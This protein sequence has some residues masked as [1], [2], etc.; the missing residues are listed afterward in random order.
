M[1]LTSFSE[2]AT[3]CTNL[4]LKIRQAAL[5][6]IR[7]MS[8]LR[9]DQKNARA[10]TGALKDL[11]RQILI[12]CLLCRRTFALDKESQQSMFG[13]VG[14]VTDYIEASVH[15]H[16]H[17]NS[18]SNQTT[19]ELEAKMLSD[20]YLARRVNGLIRVQL[21]RDD[22]AISVG[23]KRF[24]STAALTGRWRFVHECDQ[25]WIENQASSKVV[26]Y[27]LVTGSLLVSGRAISQLPAHYM[28]DPLYRSVF[29]DLELDVFAADVDDMEYVSKDEI[30][31]HRIYFAMRGKALLIRSCSGGQRF[32]AVHRDRFL[33][34]V[35]RAIVESSTP[36]MSLQDTTV[37][38]RS[39]DRP[40][41]PDLADWTLS[42]GF[43][44]GSKSTMST[45]QKK[46]IDVNGQFGASICNI[47][48][49]IESSDN[50]IITV[51][52]ESSVEVELPRYHLHF[53]LD[54]KGRL[55][56]RE[57]SA[58]VDFDQQLGTFHGLQSRLIL[59]AK[60]EVA[61]SRMRTVL[62]PI[63]EV[64]ITSAKPHVRVEVQLDDSDSLSLSQ[65][66]IDERLGQLVGQDLEAHLYKV[67]LHAITTFPELDSLTRR[68]G[69]EESLFALSDPICRTCLPL[70]M[71]A[72]NILGLISRLT[73]VRRFYPVHLKTM[74]TTTFL[75]GLS[76]VA[77]RDIFFGTANE[78]VTHNMKAGCLF[79]AQATPLHYDGQFELLQRS[80]HRTRKL[81][82]SESVASAPHSVADNEYCSRDQ[83]SNE[84]LHAS[85][86][87]ARLVGL[88]PS[89]LDVTPSLKDL[90][91][92]W[93]KIR[94]FHEETNA[95]AFTS[96]LV[97][98]MEDLLPR[99]IALCRSL[100]TSRERLAF[101]LSLI[102]FGGPAG[103]QL[104]AFGGHL[105]AALAFAI[106]PALR[107]LPIPDH[108][109]YDLSRGY[110]IDHREVGTLISLCEKEFVPSEATS[111]SEDEDGD[112]ISAEKI[113]FEQELGEQRRLILKAVKSSWPG[114]EVNFTSVSRKLSHYN[115]VDLKA[116]LD[117]RFAA[118]HKNYVFLIQLEAYDKVLVSIRSS[119]VGPAMV[120]LVQDFGST[121]PQTPPG[122]HFSLLD[123][124][125]R[126]AVTTGDY[127]ES[128][129]TCLDQD[130]S[131]SLSGKQALHLLISNQ[132]SRSL[133]ELENIVTNLM[134]DPTES[135]RC[136]G[137]LIGDS[138]K[139]SRHR[140][141]QELIKM[142]V[143]AETVLAAK[144]VES[145]RHIAYILS[146]TQDLIQP[147]LPSQQGLVTARLWP[148]VSE[149]SLLQLL[150]IDH[151]RLV[152]FTWMP[153]LVQLAKE[154]T[155]AQRIERL[156][157]FLA[158][159]D[160]FALNNE[161]A[162]PAHSAWSPESRLDWLLL[163]CQN[164]MLIRPV[165]LRVADELLKPHNGVVLLGMGEGKTSVIL[166]MVA[167]ALAD[168][169]NLVRVV[170]L[171]P[172]A[173]EM[174]RTL[175]LSLAGLVGR[176]L[177]YLPF[178]RQTTLTSETP[179]LLKSLYDECRQ[180]KGILL[181]LPEYL[182]SF[183][184]VGLDKLGPGT[185][186][187][188][189]P[190]YELVYTNGEA[191][192][193][194][195]APKRWNVA[196][197]ILDVVRKNANDLQR[198]FPTAF[199]V[200]SRGQGCFPHIRVLDDSGATP[201]ARVVTQAI[202]DGHIPTLSLGHCN[203]HVLQAISAFILDIDV[204]D[205][206]FRLLTEHF[207]DA[208]KFDL[209]YV[210]RGLISHGILSHTLGKRWLV[211]YGLD[212][213]RTLS[214]VPYRAKGFS[215][216][217]AE[218][219]Q[220]EA[221]ILLTALSFYY[222]GLLRTDLRRCLLILM[223]LPD[224]ADA[225][226]KWVRQSTLPKK[227][228]RAASINLDDASCVD[229]LYTHLKY[230]SE[231]I[232]FFLRHVVYPSEAKEFRYKLS[233]SAWDL[234]RSGKVVTGG[235]S[236]TCDSRIP[237]IQK[238]LPD[239]RHIPATTLTTLLRWENRQ[240][241][242]AASQSG[243]RLT[244]KDLLQ[245]IIAEGPVDVC[246]DVGAQMLEGN[247]EIAHL[248][249]HLSPKEK[250]AAIYFSESDQKM[251]LNRD[252]STEPLVSSI[253][254]DEL[255]SCLIFLDE[256][257]TRG[258]DFQLPD[259]FT[260]AVLL[261][262]DILKDS[263]AQACMRMRKLA[264]SQSVRF[265]APPEVDQAIRSV[266]K[267]PSEEVTSLHVVLWAIK[268]SCLT[269]K[270]QG[271]LYATRGLLHS[272]RRLAAE[273][274]VSPEGD[275]VNPESYLDTVRERECRPVSELYRVDRRSRAAMPFEPTVEEVQ[276]AV[277]KELVLEFH[278]TSDSDCQDNGITQEQEREILHEVEEERELQ[279]PREVEP[280]TPHHC[281]SLLDHV[282]D[283][284]P[285][286]GTSELRPCFDVLKQT[287]LDY[288]YKP[289]E[290]PMHV[291]VTPDFLQTIIPVGNSPQDDFLRPVQWVLKTWGLAQPVIISSH[292][293]Q[294][295]LPA[296]R[297]SKRTTL[298]MYQARTSRDM[299]PFDGLDICKIPDNNRS[300]E[301]KP[302]AI[303]LL[304]LFA[305]QL[306]FSSFN[307]YKT[308]CTVI[309][310]FDGERPLPHKRNV[311]DDNFVS[312][313]CRLANDWTE[314][315]FKTSPVGWIKSFITM[316]RL[317]IEWSHTH[318][319]RVLNGKILRREDFD[320]GDDVEHG[321]D[322]VEKMAGLTLDEKDG[323]DDSESLNAE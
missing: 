315:T 23:V 248:W 165:Q 271:P 85:S 163:E 96:L 159:G 147:L 257:H 200:E 210:V 101:V 279:R 233:T 261:G 66:R 275:I 293:A 79:D 42:P 184:L 47:F 230:N 188:A 123:R 299:V 25:T 130:L 13:S 240:Y 234:C 103:Q 59:R 321:K 161:L 113:Q 49:P 305:G 98:D 110:S 74:Q 292:E 204:E 95:D 138:I 246:I 286:P 251:V 10:D 137:K 146:K 322:L 151:R 181:T 243:G 86:T 278:V 314:C 209:L 135:V 228:Q 62:V 14:A 89:A 284:T 76:V 83:D 239:L 116:L 317:G 30:H 142:K 182:N 252:G 205:S 36:W 255:G 46:L 237:I 152:P 145:N 9:T 33:G 227:Y 319:G 241:F 34:D 281:R 133:E 238:D 24:W 20:A 183:R 312:P 102:V 39:R 122:T 207:Q 195:G 166:P 118:W 70:S 41:C 245:R 51:T 316:R 117:G 111:S 125:Q 265:Y 16:T 249:L 105:R 219:A 43:N 280:A 197:D 287:R 155:A 69:T 168:G 247:L 309:G 313:T 167:T 218:F 270:K 73:P 141:G 53:D 289:K 177:Y 15:L 258:T 259:N 176:A 308:M 29:G 267:D 320:E 1:S 229:E 323:M 65:F 37:V 75:K 172:L 61:G 22:S 109:D 6:W 222:T 302:L 72:Q 213:S 158:T 154:I 50:I 276:D 173:Q 19:L 77:Q 216:P 114:D 198:R 297:A 263:L 120:N 231:L 115:L 106:S 232:H 60:T 54:C 38:F 164:N 11:S 291:L 35:P 169:M 223:R 94:G 273:R 304:N 143:P 191:N 311:A 290:F 236:G 40:F 170:V 104:L 7:Q 57:L 300:G 196:L 92:G 18:V 8:K 144:L 318:M 55:V 187:L 256:F 121:S 126:T 192:L 58:F 156:Q 269:L 157:K 162:N 220:P 242:S 108:D 81:F 260:A 48:L 32:E 253:F 235:F 202:V 5:A 185:H 99:L 208:G 17:R 64:N 206:Q 71:R 303:A 100:S 217:S 148:Q 298:Y 266:M 153:I 26:H 225:Y 91:L 124:M 201:L 307:H 78:I 28:A 4:N 174:L 93:Q 139:A 282:R 212:R 171:K 178:S 224:P 90:V 203:P 129:P 56:C 112:V 87:M 268:Q 221:A 285:F 128:K 175:S 190:S 44:S 277:M 296:I 127:N 250:L 84:H 199:E 244:T 306:Y 107:A 131:Q 274:H 262:P 294:L 52:R 254:K 180:M 189:R 288:F 283:G 193:L 140:Q 97:Q 27:N 3:R 301:I 160:T 31:G 80:H 264:V 214:A 295:F 150:W 82:P 186:E 68:T 2:I 226:A 194:S 67:Y 12:A 63:G 134:R 21:M 211:N 119:F 215:S 136:Y 45:C 310:L 272:R 149:L 179:Q 88:W 132:A